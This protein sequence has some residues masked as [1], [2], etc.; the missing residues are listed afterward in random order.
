M[1]NNSQQNL[2]PWL[3]SYVTQQHQ[4]QS[5]YEIDKYLIEAGYSPGEIELVWKNLSQQNAAERSVL[6]WLYWTLIL[7]ILIVIPLLSTFVF[8]SLLPSTPLFVVSWFIFLIASTTLTVQQWTLIPFA[9]KILLVLF[10]LM[11]WS[12]SLLILP[13]LFVPLI[14][15]A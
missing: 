6:D 14:A 7:I 11:F 2:N 4:K 13:F 1:Q 12:F 3:L 15:T 5:R 9:V 10:L 8:L